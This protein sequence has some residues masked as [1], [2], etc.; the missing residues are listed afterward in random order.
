MKKI[1]LVL[2]V[3]ILACTVANAQVKDESVE[4]MMT[5]RVM[6]CDD[7][8]YNSIT[9]L[10][11]LYAAHKTDTLDAVVA[12]WQKNCG[13][14]E[15][16]VCVG[17]L[18]DIE[19]G[20]FREAL[21]NPYLVAENGAGAGDE[22]YYKNNI[23]SYLTSN[24]NFYALQ[25]NRDK[26]MHFRYVAYVDYSNF[27]RSLAGS[28]L[29]KPG[30]TP[31]ERFLVRFYAEPDP[32]K[33]RELSDSVYN[34]T[35]LQ[36]AYIGEQKFG[37]FDI[38]L[39]A[40]VWT[41]QGNL[42]I[43][44]SHPSVGI[45]MGGCSKRLMY[46]LVFDVRF[47]NSANKY[48]TVKDDSLRQSNNFTSYYVG[49]D[50]GYA[51]LRSRKHEL[52]LLAGIG[53]DGITVVEN[54]ANSN[55]AS[56]GKNLNSFNLNAGIGYKFFIRHIKNDNI[57]RYSYVGLQ[58]KYNLINYQNTGGTDLT[59]N[60]FTFGIIY[61]AFMRGVHHYYDVNTGY[62]SRSRRSF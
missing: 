25:L 7:V 54:T 4:N 22:L 28:L 11:Q 5:K 52:A 60:S 62:I 45:Y 47:G 50:W 21:R 27:I 12:Y 61:G 35:L 37:G 30:L 56:N 18:R 40:G 26:Y 24:Y 33:I 53:Y 13:L 48:T 57:S 41:P 20:T 32:Q 29:D 43:L 15:A 55:D 8:Y 42:S 39:R 17:I 58:A 23:I 6:T 19:K 10:P 16:S 31:A 14:S 44:G 46:D 9:L 51:V 49:L 3:A 36:Q 59:G 2:T 1:V 34:G 38:G